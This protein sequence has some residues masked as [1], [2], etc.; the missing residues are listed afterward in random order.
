MK[1]SSNYCVRNNIR[2]LHLA[3][4]RLFS[5]STTADSSS[6]LVI[7]KLSGLDDGIYVFGL[8]RPS[9]R[10]ALG[11]TLTTELLKAVEKISLISEARVLIIR[12]LVPGVFCSGADLKERLKLSNSEVA[13][14]VSRLNSLASA[15]EN[16]PIPTIAAID[17]V[18][19]GGGLEIAL[20][21]DMRTVS[22]DS[23]VGLVETKWAIMPGAGGSQRLPRLINPAI[24]KELI[25]CAKVID[26]NEAKQI[27]IV[28]Y[29]VKQNSSANAAYDK[30]LSIARQIQ[31]NG[32]LGVKMAKVSINKGLETDVLTGCKL[33]QLCYAQVIPTKDRIEGLTAFKEN[34]TP[35]YKGE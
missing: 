27:G 12:S 31:A 4:S 20:G 2:L 7:E 1:Y 6:E 17:G 9:A 11:H 34:R 35:K 8:N 30:A 10:N 26:G 25:F 23:K 24:A 18:A 19:L 28:N 33:E 5:S 21:C 13:T 14:T 3:R 15:I 32:P 16:V 29:C 22:E